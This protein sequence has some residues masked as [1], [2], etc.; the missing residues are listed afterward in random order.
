MS[1]KIMQTESLTVTR[2]MDKK[3]ALLAKG[4][5]GAFTLGKGYS[6]WVKGGHFGV[7]LGKG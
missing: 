5:H 3:M 4:G 2:V 6:L 1:A 7:L